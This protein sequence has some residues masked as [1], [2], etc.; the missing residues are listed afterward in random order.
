MMQKL[1]QLYRIESI[2]RVCD[3]ESAGIVHTFGD[4]HI[5]S[6]QLEQVELQLTR[7]PKRLPII[8]INQL[9]DITIL[10]LLQKKQNR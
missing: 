9:W 3:L 8:K 4:V 6:N 5:Y 10:I 2:A 7:E 1:P